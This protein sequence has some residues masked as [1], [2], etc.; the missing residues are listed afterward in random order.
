LI[1]KTLSHF[2]I[3]AKLGEGGMG[4]V[5]RATDTKLEREVAL[6][7]L[8]EAFTA[9]PERLAR[10]E[11]EAKVLASLDHPNIGSIFQVDRSEGR[12]FLAMAL[13]EGE[14][15]AQM[16]ARRALPW[17]EVQPLALQIAEGLEAAHEKG[18]VHR[19]LKPAN[20]MVDSGGRVKILDFGL[21]KVWEEELSAPELTHSPTLT[22]PMTRAGVLLGTAAYMSPEQVHGRAVDKRTDIWAFGCLL[23]EM[24]TGSPLFE[25][26][27]ITEV[28]AAVL[29]DEP[30]M[31]RLP[32]ALPRTVPRLIERCLRRDPLKRLRDIGDARLELEDSDRRPADS[33]PESRGSSAKVL[34]FLLGGSLAAL[35]VALV[36]AIWGWTRGNTHAVTESPVTR[37]EVALED[38]LYLAVGG[39][40][41]PLTIS[42]DGSRIVFAANIRGISQL[43]LRKVDG[44]EIEAIPG[45]EGAR[46]PFFSPNGKRVGFFAGT[47]M[48]SVGFDGGP[49]RLILESALDD[50]GSSWG[51]DGTIV[52]ASYGSGLSR[53][54]ATGGDPEILTTLD[55]EA[56]EVQHRWPQI[57]P[58]GRSV[59][60]TVATDKGSRVGLV[61][62]D[63]G[64]R[65]TLSEIADLSRA[66][67]VPSGH[68]IFG[69][70]RGLR[71]IRFD[72]ASGSTSGEAVSVLSDVASVPDLGNAFFAV[73]PAGTIVFVPGATSG[74]LELVWVDRQGRT[75]PAVE[76]KA[77][78]M[79]PELSPDDRRIAVS[80]G[81]EVGY[82]EIWIYDLER[83]TRR[84]LG[85]G[86]SHS[87]P[88]WTPD[89]KELVFSS[90]AAGS[91][92]L[93][94][95][96]AQG[97]A[98]PR[99]FVVREYEQWGG[100]WSPDGRSFL[101]YDVHPQTGRDI[102]I[103]DVESKESRP[104]L[105]TRYNERAPRISPDGRWLAYISNETGLDEVYVESFPERGQKWTLSTEGGTEPA[106]SKDGQE[107]FYRQ[108]DLM[109]VVDVSLGPEFSAAKPRP[110]FEGRYGVGS[111]GNPDYGVTADGQRFLMTKRSES[112]APVKLHV[113]LNW[114]RELADLFS[115]RK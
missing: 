23:F 17:D 86:G 35:T 10:F 100:S 3:T 45:T 40:T 102:W 42:P 64:E 9:D 98:E 103:F 43:Y 33:H 111:V 56:G 20:V 91:W 31:N 72:P 88:H 46:N 57:L 50:M 29:R 19:D 36:A 11:R 28:L 34:R 49:P 52:F 83:G 77:S 71:A 85:G 84:L 115:E 73:S 104:Y 26:R 108:G 89:G 51:R 37:W 7:V 110:L 53:V 44:F 4:A 90:N 81:A 106:W 94:V 101:Y 27:E 107:L 38:P 18:I 87:V 47:K 70:A 95:G 59:L 14:N 99:E 75:T 48:Q 15:I 78:F 30:D 114:D 1:G 109:M 24:L 25:G 21:A 105:V 61:S 8:P 112:A 80:A 76:G 22:S 79:H 60:L 6:K 97:T 63:T 41:N 62:L 74:N 55:W 39:R 69:Q 5:Y 13:V 12:H 65:K 113:I 96:G 68:L 32:R 58:D 82:R 93:Y 66:R 16:L 67:Y 2:K 54:A 92:D